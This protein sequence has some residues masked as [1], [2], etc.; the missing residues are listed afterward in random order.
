MNY[1]MNLGSLSTIGSVSTA[2]ARSATDSSSTTN[3]SF[4]PVTWST[5]SSS[6][7]LSTPPAIASWGIVCL[8]DY[9]PPN[10]SWG[11]TR[12]E[13]ANLAISLSTAILVFHST[14]WIDMWWT[15][16]DLYTSRDDISQIFLTRNFYGTHDASL[17]PPPQHSSHSKSKSVFWDLIGEPVL[18]RLGFAL[19]ELAL[20]KRLSELRPADIDPN[21]D[22]DMCDMITA[23]KILAEGSVL[24]EVGQVYH[25]A[26]QVCLTHQVIIASGIKALDSSHPS[27]QQDLE[28]FVVVPIRQFRANTWGQFSWFDEL[29]GEKNKSSVDLSLYLNSLKESNERTIEPD[30]I[31]F[32]WEVPEV[33][34]STCRQAEQPMSL[35]ETLRTAVVLIG[36]EFYYEAAI[37]EAYLEKEWGDL[38]TEIINLIISGIGSPQEDPREYPRAIYTA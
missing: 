7:S 18:T 9:L 20:G 28:R 3:S 30:W 1:V 35:S 10:Q 26:V 23:T 15:W 5:R 31:T 12:Q 29:E 2:G 11:I 21:A 25:D 4:T 27:F 14:P 34:V 17:K 6:R 24:Q 32:E 38:G 8:D 19:V 33:L 13:R 22:E 37:C 36:Y 16:K